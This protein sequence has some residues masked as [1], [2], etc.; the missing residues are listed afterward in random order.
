VRERER[1]KKKEGA[2]SNILNG[3]EWN[4]ARG[5]RKEGRKKMLSVHQPTQ[6]RVKNHDTR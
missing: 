4:F 3:K 6:Q 2:Q 1:E 5:R